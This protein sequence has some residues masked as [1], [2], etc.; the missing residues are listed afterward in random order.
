MAS[1][2]LFMTPHTSTKHNT[3]IVAHE[4]PLCRDYRYQ[5][6]TQASRQL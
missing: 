6:Q 2:V 3:A 5:F 1:K 4:L